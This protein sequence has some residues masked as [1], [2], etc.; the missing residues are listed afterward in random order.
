MSEQAIPIVGKVDGITETDAERLSVV[1]LH[2]NAVLATARLRPDGSYHLILPHAAAR[3]ASGYG[4]QL[5]VLPSRA[6]VLR[7]LTMRGMT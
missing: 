3:D 1:A 2:G 6:A 7:D 4:L 5:A